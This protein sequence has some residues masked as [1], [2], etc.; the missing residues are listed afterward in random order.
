M[1]YSVLWT[2]EAELELIEILHGASDAEAI[3]RDARRT[4]RSLQRNPLKEGESRENP[5]RRAFFV[6]S[7]VV[8]Y[9]VDVPNMT[10]FIFSVRRI[11]R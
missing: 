1:N 3:L 9:R 4:E 7:L 5:W 2:P 11:A 6:G 8:G 10:V